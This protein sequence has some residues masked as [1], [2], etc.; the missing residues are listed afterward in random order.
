MEVATTTPTSYVV[1]SKATYLLPLIKINYKETKTTEIYFISWAFFPALW[2]KLIKNEIL[3]GEVEKRAQMNIYVLFSGQFK[4]EKYII[5]Y[6][7]RIL[8]TEIS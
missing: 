6:G 7:F 4:S 1:S 8:S 2:T 5:S 3:K